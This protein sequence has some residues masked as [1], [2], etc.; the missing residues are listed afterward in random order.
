MDF[1]FDDEM[2]VE[3]LARQEHVRAL[4]ERISQ[5]WRYAPKRDN[6]RKLNPGFAGLGVIRA[7]RRLRKIKITAPFV[8]FQP[9][10]WKLV[11]N[12]K[13]LKIWNTLSGLSV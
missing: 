3:P 8:I 10:C 2:E 1:C 6:D 9:I 5:G 7:S 11:F 13:K 4:E 12:W